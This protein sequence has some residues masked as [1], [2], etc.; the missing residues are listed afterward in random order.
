MPVAGATELFSAALQL[1]LSSPCSP[2]PGAF[3]LRLG[4]ARRPDDHRPARPRSIMN[5]HHR[6]TS[7]RVRTLLAP[8]AAVALVAGALPVL[9]AAPALADGT[10]LHV[11]FQPA[12]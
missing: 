9:S 4:R 12:G 1:D 3:A 2:F 5:L 10:S 11:N 7:R 8:L 6:P